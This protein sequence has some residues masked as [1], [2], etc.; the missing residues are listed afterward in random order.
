VLMF[1]FAALLFCLVCLVLLCSALGPYCYTVDIYFQMFAMW[2][3]AQD[4]KECDEKCHPAGNH[5]WG[6][7]KADPGHHHKQT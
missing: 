2:K 6:H 3:L 7:H 5:I 4:K 1:Y